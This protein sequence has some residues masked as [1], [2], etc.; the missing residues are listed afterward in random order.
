MEAIGEK[1][2]EAEQKLEGAKAVVKQWVAKCK[3]LKTES[4]LALEA[5]EA[6]ET[7]ALAALESGRSAH[8]EEVERLEDA[9]ASFASVQGLATELLQQLVTEPEQLVAA[10][11][12]RTEPE[13]EPEPEAV[14]PPPPR[15]GFRGC[16]CEFPREFLGDQ[17]SRSALETFMET[18]PPGL[19]TA[20]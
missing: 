16:L 13:P 5:I 1:V 4:A 12:P 17:A 11:E 19:D 10:T 8:A 20:L 9:K 14:P 7:K 15:P 18:F 6:R 3:E 2:A